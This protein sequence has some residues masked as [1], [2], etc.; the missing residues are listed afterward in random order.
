GWNYYRPTDAG[1]IALNQSPFGAIAG[2]GKSTVG[3]FNVGAGL[4]MR[5]M[6]RL[7]MDFSVRDFVQRSPDF[8]FPESSD[9][10]LDNDIQ[11]Q[12]GLHFTFGGG[13]PMIVH[14]FMVGPAIMASNAAVCPGESTVL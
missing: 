14:T 13:G 5:L 6:E 7:A 8:N 10:D 3:S 9:R 12:L 11:L 4:K 2:T 1:Q